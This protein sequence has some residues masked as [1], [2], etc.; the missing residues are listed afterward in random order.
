[1]HPGVSVVSSHKR[2]LNAEMRKPEYIMINTELMPGI[3][4]LSQ[5]SFNSFSVNGMPLLYSHTGAV[6]VVWN[7]FCLA[8]KRNW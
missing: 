4:T 7:Y 6:F 8:S 5:S 3:S 1:M 2:F